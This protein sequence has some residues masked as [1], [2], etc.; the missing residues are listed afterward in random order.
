MKNDPSIK[1]MSWMCHALLTPM[2]GLTLAEQIRKRGG[3]GG[4]REEVKGGS[5]RR[6]GRK[7]C[8]WAVK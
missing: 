2:G 6:E 8:G 4:G 1:Y 3:L 7:S 5:G